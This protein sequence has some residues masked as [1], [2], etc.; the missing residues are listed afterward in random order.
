[1]ILPLNLSRMTDLPGMALLAQVDGSFWLPPQRS[2]TAASVDAVF[3]LIFWISAFFFALIVT[4]MIVFVVRYRRRP[5]EEAPGSPSHNLLL[6]VAWSA[7]PFA[8]VVWIFYLSLVVYIEIRTSPR[9]AYE[10]RVIGQKWSWAFRYPNDYVDENLHVPVGEPVRL[11]MMSEDVIHSLSIPDFRVKMDLVPGRYTKT[12]FQATKPGTYDL[13]CTEY[14]GTGHSSMLA[15]V[16]VHRAGGFKTWLEGASN[17]LETMDPVEAGKLLYQKR[18]CSQCHTTDRSSLVGPGFEGIFG[19][20]HRFLDGSTAEV[21]ENYLRQSILEPSA[22]VREGYR[23]QMP[24]YKGILSDD[25][26]DVIIDFIKS[27]K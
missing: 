3:D 21:D 9:E 13:Y 4:L 11:V 20:V 24:T 22:K 1:M 17:F 6:E 8:L 19:Q 23:D 16:V 14:C 18:G 15:S 7:I 26:I 25:E 10:I 5:G 27:R 2:T 12:W